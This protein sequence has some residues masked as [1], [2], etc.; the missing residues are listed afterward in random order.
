ML[1]LKFSDLVQVLDEI[2]QMLT[3]PKFQ[4][5][6][7]VVLAGYEA[8]IE[9]LM[10]VNPGLKSR[11]SEKLHF[12]DFSVDDAGHLLLLELG[13]QYDLRLSPAAERELP[14]LMHQV[15]KGLGFKV[16]LR[17]MQQLKE[18]L[19]RLNKKT[20]YGG[21]VGIGCLRWSLGK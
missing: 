17:V 11:F 7:V 13:K 16:L 18:G 6:M 21:R 1:C 4:G 3:E 5:K 2:V 19:L 20:S 12:P 14:Q 9:E 8:Q 10:V 15:S